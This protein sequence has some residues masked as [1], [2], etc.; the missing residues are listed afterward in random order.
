MTARDDYIRG[1]L[2]LHLTELVPPVLRRSLFADEAFSTSLCLATDGIISFNPAGAAFQR[3]ALF[4]AVRAASKSDDA[5]A[6]QVE[7]GA[8]WAVRFDRQENPLVV[9]IENGMRK[10]R[11]RHL[12]L[13]SERLD[14]R[15]GVLDAEA[16]RVNL[17]RDAHERWVALIDTRSLTDTEANDF[18]EDINAT[19]VAV[20]AAISGALRQESAEFDA[21][22]PRSAIYY[23]RLVGCWQGQADI[24][25]YA[26][27]VLPGVFD[28]LLA[29]DAEAGFRLALLLCSHPFVVERLAGKTVT[30]TAF[31]V[32]ARWARDSAD[33]MTRCAL[34]ELALLRDHIA[35]QTKPVLAEMAASLR[36]PAD[37]TDVDFEL[38]SA[39]FVF[40]YGQLSHLKI[41]ADR[42][43]F[44]GRIAALAQAGL[45][46]RCFAGRR[47]AFVEFVQELH[48]ARARPFA[49]QVYADM[50]LGPMWQSQFAIP[51]QL[52][53]EFVGRVVSRAALR[54]DP[55]R[56]LGLHDAI[57]GEVE[58]LN[59]RSLFDATRGTIGRYCAAGARIGGR[60]CGGGRSRSHGTQADGP[61]LRTARQFRI[62]VSAIDGTGRQG[63]GDTAAGAISPRSRK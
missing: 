53:N 52:R 59:H 38:L 24:A 55:A 54:E 11:V 13:L 7:A 33:A 36:K 58:S 62:P 57:L 49:L 4:A 17:P 18:S 47:A 8:P 20:S 9:V 27:T 2:A 25:A 10:I 15:R 39:A 44:W 60:I 42:P 51:P 26:E 30:P 12:G 3:S 35:E 32:V 5:V 43:T 1:S 14:D 56:L 23:E 45:I 37:G 63:R 21:L 28:S 48:G 61:F 34:L 16:A 50:R 22:V 29:F 46:V 6:I 40:V 31:D 41:L 19:P